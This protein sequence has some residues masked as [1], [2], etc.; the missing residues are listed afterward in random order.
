MATIKV[1]IKTLN[2]SIT[3][4]KALRDKCNNFDTTSPAIVGGGETVTQ[5]EDIASLYKSLNIHF[6]E[7]VNNTALFME[8]VKTSYE[9]SDKKA[10]NKMSDKN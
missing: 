6:A 8:N 3:K 5:L 1:N 9:S 10:A 2:D 4:L 7:L